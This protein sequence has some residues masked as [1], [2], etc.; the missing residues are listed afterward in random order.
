[1]LTALVF[2][3]A[4]SAADASRAAFATDA[5]Q[6]EA[7]GMSLTAY[8]GG[9]LQVADNAN[10]SG[11]KEVIFSD[12]G[13]AT[14][15]FDGQ[16]THVLVRAKGQ[17]CD[18]APMMVV[19]VDGSRVGETPIH[20]KRYADYDYEVSSL[21]AQV[22]TLKVEFTN[23]YSSAKCDRNLT[24]DYATVT[25]PDISPPPTTECPVGQFSAEY[26]NE[27]Q[28]FTS[29]PVLT[30]C[31]SAPLDYDWS[32]GSPGT[33]V[34][35]DNFTSLFEG[36]FQFESGD[37]EF[38]VETNDGI[39]VYVDD[40]RIIDEWYDHSGSHT[41]TITMRAGEHTVRVE[42]YEGATDAKVAV[43]WAKQTPELPSGAVMKADE[44]VSSVGVNTHMTFT[45]M[46]AYK[47]YAAVTD[48]LTGA[49]IR[50]IREHVYYEPGHPNDVERY[51]KLRYIAQNGIKVSCISDQRF[52]GMNPITTEKINYIHTQSGGACGAY[53]GV[54][55]YDISSAWSANPQDAANSLV[56]YTASLSTAVKTNPSTAY[57][58][59]VGPSLVK[60]ESKDLLGSRLDAFVDYG[61]MH[62]YHQDFHPSSDGAPDMSDRLVAARALT[63]SHAMWS[64]EDGWDTSP[65]A[66]DKSVSEN[67]QSKYT[68]RQM[69]WALFDAKFDKTIIYS[70]LDEYEDLS[71]GDNEAHYG[72]VR[73]D[74][75]PKPAYYSVQRLLGL[76]AEPNAPAFEPQPLGY[77][78][79]GS[80][81][82]V[83]AYVLQKST[84]THYVVLYQDV[85]SWNPYTNSEISNPPV[86]VR[87]DLA[88]PASRLVVHSPQRGVTP[89][90]DT[91]GPVSGVSLNVPDHPI[92]VEVFH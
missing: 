79:S 90:S 77:S 34:N 57:V 7:E 19:S 49:N 60:K 80:T 69:F 37:Y 64:T 28:G 5:A 55:E 53:E 12:N 21:T 41:A 14:K 83:K 85:P 24:V 73:R 32:T 3:F 61:N 65:D 48:L 1:L 72:I 39:R 38:D 68:L 46:D 27:V 88:N 23:D 4:V 16:P 20:R 2:S 29:S 40:Q 50:W 82:D 8:E 42:H 66:A 92:V 70:L 45:W 74:M 89:E 22:H 84:G 71:G 11:G 81:Q 17:S 25:F 13:S 67:V 58:P 63:S 30:S 26:R 51:R 62:P 6:F 43:S 56:G 54:N 44:F 75:T 36:T 59:V 18:G 87:L 76:L 52:A 78:L 10:A 15:S 86:S 9:R 91:S 31:V 33:D 47:D 35:S